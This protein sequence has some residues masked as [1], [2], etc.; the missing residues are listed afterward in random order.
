MRTHILASLTFLASLLNSHTHAHRAWRH[1]FHVTAYCTG[2]TTATQTR[3]GWGS[4][5]VDP[6]YVPFYSH[7]RIPGYGY[8]RALDTGSA[9]VGWRLDVYIPNCWNA[10][11]VWGNRWVKVTVWN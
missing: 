11:H 4:V 3:V 10:I 9:I 7:L 6:R 1:W 2:T 5:A 8:G